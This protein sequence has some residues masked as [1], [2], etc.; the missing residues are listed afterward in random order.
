MCSF[1]PF[2]EVISFMGSS[3][4]SVR[5]PGVFVHLN[6]IPTAHFQYQFGTLE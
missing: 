3:Q 4:C 2:Y 5:H 1:I 6:P